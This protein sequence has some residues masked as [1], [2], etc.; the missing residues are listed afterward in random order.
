MLLKNVMGWLAAGMVASTG[1]AQESSGAVQFNSTT[2]FTF[3]S[4][5]VFRGQKHA[6]ESVQPSVEGS[7]KDTYLGLWMNQ[8]F[9]RQ[10]GNEMDLYG[11]YR[12]KISPALTLEAVGTYYL[13][14]EA[15][16][17]DNR[18]SLEAGMG[19]RYVL[20]GIASTVFYY[21]DFK[22]N[23][24]TIQGALS[25]SIPLEKIGG[26]LDLNLFAGSVSAADAAPWS[27]NR[28]KQSYNYYGA[29][30]TLP[31]RVTAATTVSL[32]VHWS[33]SARL[34]GSGGGNYLWFTLGANWVF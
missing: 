32:G 29:D 13:Y 21:R 33:E 2:D 27:G 18:H 3:A 16:G 15:K 17:P 23:A 1:F 6:N 25:Y 28:V 12:Y 9:R 14:P 22:L 8:P 4:S 5:Y 19:A 24:D 20:R 30:A 7:F 11:G 26:S 34:S 31:Y 10:T